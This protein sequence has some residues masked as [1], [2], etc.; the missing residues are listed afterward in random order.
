MGDF[1]ELFFEDAV[2]A[3]AILD[4]ALTRRGRQD[5]E[6]IPMCGVPVHSAESYLERL[7][8]SG[9]KIAI[10][11]QMETQEEA[12]KRGAKAV[13][14]REV[15]RIVTPGTITEETLLTARQSNLLTALHKGKG[16]Y[17]LAWLELSTGE[18]GVASAQAAFLA[19]ELARLAPSEIL[20]VES[21]MRALGTESFW[22]EWKERATP[23]PDHDFDPRKAE[24]RLKETYRLETLEALGN[25]SREELAVCGAIVEYVAL[26]Q[27]SACL[28]L[29]KPRLRQASA[30]MTIDAATRRNLELT[31]TLSGERKGSLLATVDLTVTGP[32]ARL[33]AARIGAPLTEIR[34][35]ED[36]HDQI[37]FF[38]AQSGLR[39]EA[40][41]VL[42]ACPD[43]QRALSR[44][45]FGRGGP[46]D[47]L[48][49]KQALL[50]AQSLKT[51]LGDH[52]EALPSSLHTAFARLPD[53]GALIR[54][55][56][57]GVSEEAGIQASA[58]NFILPG[59]HP[60]LDEF[61]KL[62]D[63]GKR[64]IAALEARY[65]QETGIAGL[66][67]RYNNILGYYAE[68]T[69]L[70]QKKITQ[71]FIHRQTLANNLRYTT[72]ELGTLERRLSE[73][74]DRALKL[75]Q[76]LFATLCGMATQATET[77]LCAGRFLA[78]IDV[79]AALAELA[80]A[81]G[82]VRPKL[83]A[84]DAFEIEGGR[85]PVVETRLA[86]ESFIANDCDLGR[87]QRLWLLTGPNM[88]GKSTF[89][90]QNA[91]IAILAQAGSFVP[92]RR[93]RIGVI[94]SLFSRVGAADDLAR[95]RSTFMVEMV[96][97]AAILNLATSR[98]LVILDE[99]G[100]GTATFDGLSIA[101]AVVEYLHDKLACR[102]LFATH[103]HEM[104]A[105]AAKLPALSCRTMKVKEWN[106][107]VIFLHEVAAGAAD[108]SYG[109]HVARIAGLPEAVLKRA[110]QVLHTLESTQGTKLAQQLAGDLPLFSLPPAPLAPVAPQVSAAEAMLR[111][112]DPDALTPRAAL[113]RLYALKAALA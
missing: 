112:I 70:H 48:A 34:A 41:K 93:A 74:S 33:L 84:S 110:S 19:G 78:E 58:G 6:D 75:E 103:Y 90:R 100:R 5:G 47:L 91:L 81:R 2:Q 39:A 53:H 55:L 67:I 56:E 102:A 71:D 87:A 35:I 108:R 10:C 88:A 32:G 3:A 113:E 98:S 101:W 52:L 63:E 14:R 54:E 11:E 72:S 7:I 109:I 68:I 106:Q 92:A 73:A 23:R 45:N 99:I 69:A 25:F 9:A 31:L 38:L 64:L 36:R 40:R 20:L 12:K 79:N 85:H 37:A 8:A 43:P 13:M 104:T 65:Q 94:D 61:R 49:L 16:G 57:A 15:V 51:L 107:E 21:S 29:E 96:E 95:G 111:D 17:A 18:F 50:A 80:A 59:Y 44:L 26:T 89:L 83:E 62:R 105:L 76:E 4:I 97:T 1:Y 27:K 28:R 60:P 22:H 30:I 24:H 86:G 77:I 42:R 46:R 66:K 82:Y